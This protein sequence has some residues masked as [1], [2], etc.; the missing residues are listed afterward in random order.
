[1]R[2]DL[3]S[4]KLIINNATLSSYAEKHDNDDEYV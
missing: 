3:N 4:E 2:A 1:M